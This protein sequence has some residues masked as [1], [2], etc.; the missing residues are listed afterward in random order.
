MFLK[1]DEEGNEC[2]SLFVRYSASTKKL[3][4]EEIYDFRNTRT[5]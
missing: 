1:K 5:K 4:G 2:S 3:E